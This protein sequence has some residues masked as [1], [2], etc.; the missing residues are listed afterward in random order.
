MFSNLNHPQWV[1]FEWP[2]TFF[3]LGLSFE[4]IFMC[5]CKVFPRALSLS[6]SFSLFLS[7]SL[8]LWLSSNYLQIGKSTMFSFHGSL[9]NI[10]SDRR[11]ESPS[12]YVFRKGWELYLSSLQFDEKLEFSCS[13]CP[14][15]PDLVLFDGT[16][17]SCR[18]DQLAFTPE[19]P[20]NV[21]DVGSS[22][23]KRTT[24]SK[25]AKRE[26]DGFLSSSQSSPIEKEKL[27]SI[28]SVLP[29][30]FRELLTLV[31]VN[32]EATVSSFQRNLQMTK[33]NSTNL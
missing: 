8:F 24:L 15:T 18:K 14:E 32:F 11:M 29:P 12:Y 9:A 13:L 23:Q 31:A 6:L 7:L 3:S 33:L 25:P 1:F 10:L 21:V 20:S 28:L 4:T 2:P 22:H 19:E 27:F 17:V 16:M 26:I 30:S 5:L